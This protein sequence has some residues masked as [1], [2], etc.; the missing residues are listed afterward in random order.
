MSKHDILCPCCNEGRMDEIQSKLMNAVPDGVR[1]FWL[2]FVH[3]DDGH[4]LGACCLR[5]DWFEDDFALSM[6]AAVR[7]AHNLG[8][9]P[10]GE[11]AGWVVDT[12]KVESEVPEHLR[13]TLL[14]KWQAE[15]E[16]G[17]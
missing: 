1:W 4:F 3:P 15:N 7:A 17:R 5:A 8:I 2:S 11:V 6:C 16:I 13:E 12:E 10:G 9:N 14:T